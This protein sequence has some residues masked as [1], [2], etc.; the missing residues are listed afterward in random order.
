M[1]N[2]WVELQV[3]TQG[4]HHLPQKKNDKK[5]LKS[6]RSA[7]TE[8]TKLKNIYHSMIQSC[9]MPP[10]TYNQAQAFFIDSNLPENNFKRFT[11]E[12]FFIL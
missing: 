4:Y 10:P 8:A 9:D 7:R 6:E 3:T 11:N 5:W 2:I 12:I 1:Q